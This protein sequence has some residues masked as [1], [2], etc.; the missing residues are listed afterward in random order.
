MKTIKVVGV[1][2][3]GTMGNGIA[4]VFARG[5]FQVVLCEV[6][7]RFLDRGLEAIR[8][9][10]QREAAKGK[11]TPVEAEAALGLIRGTLQAQD[12]MACDFVI[13]A[14]PER[15]ALKQ[16]VFMQLDLLLKPEVILASNTSSISITRLAAQTQR[17]S[18]VIGMH[19][20]NP[21]PVMKLV[22]VIRGLETTDETFAQ[23][24]AL[25]E[26]LGKTPVEVND[27]PGFVSN[28]VLM[29]L[30]NEAMYAVM[31]GVATAAA[32]DQVFQLGM[33]HPMGPLALADF[34]GLDVCLDIMRVMQEGLG[35][36][37]YRPCPLL[38]RM[39]D[40]GWL[41]R[42]SGRGFYQY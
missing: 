26:G 35:D 8:K 31:E 15:F 10:L 25:A 1:V 6:E 32:V 13:E 3:A 21:V 4:H 9:N 11:L 16:E 2:G 28:R 18:Q 34:I 23:V 39:V 41:G 37:K 20:F 30:L 7:Q 33:A 12:L 38:I 5:G 36:P 27:A 42:K 14:A 40:A 17:P 22:E 29:P 24:K 19:F